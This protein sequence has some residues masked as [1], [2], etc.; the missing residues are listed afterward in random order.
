VSELDDVFSGRQIANI[1][2]ALAMVA[3]PD[4]SPLEVLAAVVVAVGGGPHRAIREPLETISQRL[5]RE[6]RVSNQAMVKLIREARR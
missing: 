4:L 5:M 3:N 6:H 2:A 1:A